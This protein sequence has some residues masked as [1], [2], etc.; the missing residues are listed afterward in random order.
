MKNSYS[1]IP[2]STY[3]T[4]FNPTHVTKSAFPQVTKLLCKIFAILIL[5]D[6]TSFVNK[7]GQQVLAES[8]KFSSGDLVIYIRQVSD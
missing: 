5:L 6:T 8:L 4:K 7:L 2:V 1:T 3:Q